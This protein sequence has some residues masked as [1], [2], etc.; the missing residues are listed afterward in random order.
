MKNSF[1]YSLIFSHNLTCAVYKT[2]L[3]Y[4]GEYIV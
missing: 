2:R 4:I 1:G 3:G